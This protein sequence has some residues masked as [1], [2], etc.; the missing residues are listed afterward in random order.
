MYLSFCT[1]TADPNHFPHNISQSFIQHFWVT[2]KKKVIRLLCRQCTRAHFY[3]IPRN[4]PYKK[5]GNSG[6][7]CI[8]SAYII[9]MY[10]YF[11]YWRLLF[12]I[13]SIDSVATWGG[14]KKTMKQRN[15]TF[16][17]NIVDNIFLLSNFWWNNYL[18]FFNIFC[19]FNAWWILRFLFVIKMDHN[20][21]GKLS[22]TKTYI[23]I[24][25][26]LKKD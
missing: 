25:F 12:G 24:I 18:T 16:S 21:I 23:N 11:I 20:L 15:N 3:V 4:I 17:K 2:Y 7:F 26:E 6:N 13:E 5:L 8:K 9:Y 1:Q 19:L 22:K 14:I 10:V